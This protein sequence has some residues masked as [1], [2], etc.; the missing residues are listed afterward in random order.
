LINK[1]VTE[2]LSVT[3]DSGENKSL[4][5]KDKTANNLSANYINPEDNADL[6]RLCIEDQDWGMVASLV[7]SWD[8][9]YKMEVWSCLSD[10]EK[11][12]LRN[13]KNPQDLKEVEIETYIPG[14]IP[15]L[16]EK[17]WYWCKSKKS[18]VRIFIASVTGSLVN[19]FLES[20]KSFFYV[21]ATDLFCCESSPRSNLKIGDKVN[22]LSSGKPAMISNIEGPII[23]LKSQK[24]G[25]TI[26]GEFF[27]HQISKD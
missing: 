11:Q 21:E 18:R 20:N 1:G 15:L 8:P 27:P 24:G 13:L 10:S 17:E 9:G 14:A 3:T 2:T 26:K 23:Y 7:E 16:K 22:I 5:V 19:I 12:A 25:R 6:L 4:L